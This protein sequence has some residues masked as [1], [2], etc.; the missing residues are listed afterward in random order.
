MALKNQHVSLGSSS[1]GPLVSAWRCVG[2][3]SVPLSTG[4]RPSVACCATRVQ[5][6]G[7]PKKPKAPETMHRETS[8]LVWVSSGR[9]SYPWFCIGQDAGFIT[10]TAH[11]SRARDTRIRMRGKK[12]IA[13]SGGRPLGYRSDFHFGLLAKGCITWNCTQI[14]SN[15]A[16][17][18]LGH[19]AKCLDSDYPGT[20]QLCKTLA[21]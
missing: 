19:Q 13:G 5:G 10:C 14:L 15:A 8:W 18:K 16:C 4:R 9:Q 7:A 2:S 21:F 12:D 3:L 11:L 6:Q 20:A 17:C 1:G